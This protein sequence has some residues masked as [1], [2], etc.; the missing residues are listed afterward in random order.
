MHGHPSTTQH[1]TTELA[2]LDALYRRSK[3]QHRSQ[4]FLQRQYQVLRLGKL[5]LRATSAQNLAKLITKLINALFTASRSTS[6]IIELLHFLPLQT[7]LLG[8]YARLFAIC[9]SLVQSLGLDIGEIVSGRKRSKRRVDSDDA[10]GQEKGKARAEVVGGVEIGERVQ[11]K[12]VQV[13]A[14]EEETGRADKLRPGREDHREIV[15]DIDLS[16]EIPV[17]PLPKINPAPI[18]PAPPV[19]PASKTPRSPSSAP[20]ERTA[21]RPTAPPFSKPKPKRA[22]SPAK[23]DK[24]KKKRKKGVMD[25]IFGF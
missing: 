6:Q 22:V 13:E 15:L 23:T 2:L 16:P 24:E 19:S 11:R 20:P 7:L 21:S 5:V 1:L 14:K 12:V 3:D 8:I 10:A 18:P 25:D 17:V 4:L 9:T